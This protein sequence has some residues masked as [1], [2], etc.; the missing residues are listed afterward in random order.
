MSLLASK[1]NFVHE[2][3]H[4]KTKRCQSVYFGLPPPFELKGGK[5]NECASRC[6]IIIPDGVQLLTLSVLFNQN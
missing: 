6:I 1:T 4:G 5:S 2:G 3:E